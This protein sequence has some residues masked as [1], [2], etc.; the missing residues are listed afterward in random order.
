MILRK[1]ISIMK[2]AINYRFI[3][4]IPFS[5]SIRVST[6]LSEESA[7]IS[8]SFC[9][10]VE[11]AMKA[12]REAELAEQASSNDK[13][14]S[15][16]RT[17]PIHNQRDRVK[18]G[19]TPRSPQQRQQQSDPSPKM[20]MSD[21]LRQQNKKSPAGAPNAAS[22]SKMGGHRATMGSA[23]LVCIVSA[24]TAAPPA[25]I[26]FLSSLPASFPSPRSIGRGGSGARTGAGAGAEQLVGELLRARY[27]QA[28]QAKADKARAAAL[29]RARCSVSRALARP[30]E[31][32]LSLYNG[33]QEDW[34]PP[35]HR[36]PLGPSFSL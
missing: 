31:R 1:Q 4:F 10:Q 20:S 33:P 6:Q 26:L 18:S 30:V 8:L 36:S 11:R 15:R 16:T 23:G 14:S 28:Q 13:K 34:D 2:R 7:I 3:Q 27:E 21:L 19:G 35:T 29:H 12:A 5:D 17:K 9:M 25:P 24:T 22:E 32:I